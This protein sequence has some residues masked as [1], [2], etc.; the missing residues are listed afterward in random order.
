MLN[1]LAPLLREVVVSHVKDWGGVGEYL[2][3][4]SKD[5]PDNSKSIDNSGRK[6]SPMPKRKAAI[7]NYGDEEVDDTGSGGK[8]VGGM[9]WEKDRPLSS[10]V[11]SSFKRDQHSRV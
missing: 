11:S 4:I 5:K 9:D 10:R 7:R 3:T 2:A 1:A 6:I 8:E